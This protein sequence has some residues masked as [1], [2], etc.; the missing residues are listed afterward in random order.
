MDSDDDFIEK[1]PAADPTPVKKLR[2][3]N[4][5]R[6]SIPKPIDLVGLTE[7]DN[8]NGNSTINVNSTA[9]NVALSTPPT[10]ENNGDL[11]PG[12][13][14]H[15]HEA[16]GRTFYRHS[17]PN[18]AT[19]FIPP[20]TK[21][22][23]DLLS[24]WTVHYDDNLGR[25][26]YYHKETDK[27]KYKKPKDPA[28]I[29]KRVVKKVKTDT[30]VATSSSTGTSGSQPTTTSSSTTTTTTTMTIPVPTTTLDPSQIPPEHLSLAPPA[31]APE[32]L[33]EISKSGKCI[34]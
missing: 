7:D 27:C 32:Y 29:K 16:S 11:L 22:N 26:F 28:T 19:Q 34:L 3:S 30:E 9:S 1:P 18:L 2:K 33:A 12:W 5:N 17:N 14:V 10:Q 21:N 6:S 31:D 13:G 25:I 15:I 20:T 4:T 24:G 8:G 23:G